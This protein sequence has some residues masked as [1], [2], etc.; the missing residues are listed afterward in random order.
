[1]MDGKA[2]LPEDIRIRLKNYINN[3]T[4]LYFKDYDLKDLDKVIISRMKERGF[5][6]PFSYYTYVT[7]SGEKEDELREL[8]N[9]ITI[10][11]TYFFR[12]EP[13]F[14]AIQKRILPEIMDKKRIEAMEKGLDKPTIRIW[15]AGCATGEEPYSIAMVIRDSIPDLDNWNIQI[16]AT[17]A[18]QEALDMARKGVYGTNSMRLVDQNHKDLYFIEKEK[19]GV[20][21]KFAIRDEVKHMVTFGFHNL[22]EEEYPAGFD[23]I[24]CRNV[25]I[26]FEL[27]T[28]INVMRKFYSSLNDN[29]YLFIGYS[30][31][32]Y[33]LSDE[34][35]MVSWNEAIY[36]R[37]ITAEAALKEKAEIPLAKSMDEELK[38]ALEEI[39]KKELEAEIKMAS[40][41]EA[42]PAKDMKEM[43]VQAIK[44]THM[45]EYARALKLLEEAASLDNKAFDPYY[46]MA[47]IYMNQGR[48][49]EAKEKLK[50]AL[51]LNPMFA[52]AHYLLGCVYVESQD[53]DQAKEN[54][55]KSL[56]IDKDLALAHFYMGAVHKTEGRIDAAIREYRNTLKNLSMY[57]PDDIIAYSGGF[58]AATLMSVCRDNIERLKISG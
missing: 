34:F 27:D 54:L 58:T 3:R 30:E 5:D 57:K 50:G 47:E 17:D 37:K 42:P 39:S 55:K 12:N 2:A 41:L 16:I 10:K 18:S 45:K 8:L 24:F 29:G 48:F 1:M 28:T 15:S 23:I 32:L 7:T 9:R 56:Y 36:Y 44:A 33:F 53:F 25:V 22:I 4:G 26:Y 19:K 52:P 20:D 6:A 13:Q 40:G 31:T 21:E 51:D 11:H 14:S 46:L 38:E 35:K 49:S 43:L